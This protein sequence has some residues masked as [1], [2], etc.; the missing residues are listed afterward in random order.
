MSANRGIPGLVRHL[1]HGTPAQQATAAGVLSKMLADAARSPEHDATAGAAAA[2]IP[3]L[4]DILVT[5]RN[6]GLLRLA[7]ISLSFLARRSPQRATAILAAGGGATLVRGM[8]SDDAVLQD[9]ATE[10]L[11]CIME[12]AAAAS[13]GTDADIATMEQAGAIPLAARLLSSS[14]STAGI[15]LCSVAVLL[16]MVHNSPSRCLAI[17][18]A[19]GTA[20]LVRC[21]K[22]SSSEPV[23]G[24]ATAALF[25]L[26]RGSAERCAAVAAAGGAAA[27]LAFLARP[28]S[29]NSRF[30][31]V[32]LLSSLAVNG[33]SQAVVAA[34]PSNAAEAALEDGLQRTVSDQ[35]DKADLE[36]ALRSPAAARLRQPPPRVCSAPGCGTTE[37]RL[38]RCGACGTV[39]YCSAACQ[40]AHW[41][42]HRKLCKRSA[43]AAEAAGSSSVAV[44]SQP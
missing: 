23:Q 26:V 7:A 41:P 34:D 43:A 30:F 1:E 22:R 29:Q 27:C 25:L 24:Q 28:A 3:A 2:A 33:Q 38:N 18:S 44:P 21:L 42:A 19:G 36:A 15:E 8:R 10:A 11:T 35:S 32:L 17:H 12:I 39:R 20:A 40:A 9:N 6:I 31:A 13:R 4:V 14:R 5:S 16:N 37:G